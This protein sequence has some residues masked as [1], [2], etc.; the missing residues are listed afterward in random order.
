[1]AQTLPM[2][3]IN[4][5]I[6]SL[7]NDKAAP[8][9]RDDELPLSIVLQP[10]YDTLLLLDLGMFPFGSADVKQ[11]LQ[12]WQSNEYEGWDGGFLVELFDGRRAEIMAQAEGFNWNAAT[13]IVVAFWPDDIDYLS[14]DLPHNHPARIYD[15]FTEA[16]E[17]NAFLDDLH[18]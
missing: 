18:S 14:E 16:P 10:F 12:T 5:R 11:V 2:N 13:K 17:I 4:V 6:R 3:A 8:E 9:E 1:M 15:V 7:A